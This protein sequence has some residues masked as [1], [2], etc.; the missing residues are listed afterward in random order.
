MKTR[1]KTTCQERRRTSHRS[2]STAAWKEFAVPKRSVSEDSPNLGHLSSAAGEKFQSVD[3]PESIAEQID[4][5][6]PD[7]LLEESEEDQYLDAEQE[8]DVPERRTA[9]ED[10]VQYYFRDIAKIP[11]LS[12]Q[13]TIKLF[14]ELQSA[15]K[16][17]QEADRLRLKQTLVLANLRLV[18]MLAKK[19]TSCGLPLL[20]IIQAGNIG[21]MRAVDGFDPNL[22][23]KFSTYASRWILASIIRMISNQGRIV[24]IPVNIIPTL[25]KVA[26]VNQKLERKL[27]RQP[28]RS[29]VAEVIGMDGEYIRSMDNMLKVSISLDQPLDQE[30]SNTI[31]SL[32]QSD[33]SDSS[34]E[35]KIDTK[36]IR[37]RID[38]LFKDLDPREQ[39][40]LK[41]RYGLE[42]GIQYTQSEIAKQMNFSRQRVSQLEKRAILRLR[43]SGGI[44]ALRSYLN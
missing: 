3:D 11:L 14:C 18:V 8:K 43:A 13:E 4:V 25:R 40:V 26:T 15:C 6:D 29:E 31:L 2:R 17:N 20:D 19:F 12:A 42:D 16:N 1:Q 35:K 41:L 27:G 5:L 10:M 44:H 9:N 36:L 34:I 33:A 28:T 24:K 22:G 37:E 38:E 32:M 7:M 30:N 21:L 23:F 39:K